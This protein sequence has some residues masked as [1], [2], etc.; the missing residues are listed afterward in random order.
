MDRI[1]N[2]GQFY[3][4]FVNWFEDTEDAEE[5]DFVDNLLLWWNQ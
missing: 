5:K 2:H 3:N 4:S 1:Y